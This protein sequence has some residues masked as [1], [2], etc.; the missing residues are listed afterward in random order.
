MTDS[1]VGDHTFEHS[2]TKSDPGYGFSSNVSKIIHK[3][4]ANHYENL[5]RNVNRTQA[6]SYYICLVHI[7]NLL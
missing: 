7:F 5:T 1:R 6:P 2:I 3:N 4:G